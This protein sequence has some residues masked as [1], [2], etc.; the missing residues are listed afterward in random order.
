MQLKINTLDVLKGKFSATLQKVQG[1]LSE[2]KGD[3]EVR[4]SYNATAVS[5]RMRKI[6]DALDEDILNL[7]REITL[8][9]EGFTVKTRIYEQ[10][11]AV[12]ATTNL[13][14]SIWSLLKD[15]T[16]RPETHEKL[17]LYLNTIERQNNS[18]LEQLKKQ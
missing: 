1:Y 7:S 17:K 9:S 13:S 16:I 14:L 4:Q 8:P 3:E 12:E 6:K 10:E 18:I 2:A 15:T 5:G 11:A